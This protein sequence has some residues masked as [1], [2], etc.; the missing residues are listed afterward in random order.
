VNPRYGTFPLARPGTGSRNLRDSGA[1]PQ[2]GLRV[3]CLV[4]ARR[5]GNRRGA[6]GSGAQPSDSIGCLFRVDPSWTERGLFAPRTRASPAGEWLRIAIPGPNWIQIQ[7]A[8]RR[9][10]SMYV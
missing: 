6:P 1:S 7:F 9:R 4:I 2:V 3:I 8:D 10:R 5:R